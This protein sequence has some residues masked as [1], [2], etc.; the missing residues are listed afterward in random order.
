MRLLIHHHAI[1][2]QDEKGFWFPSFIGAWLNELANKFESIS[3]L[4]QVSLNKNDNLDFF[5]SKDDIRFISFGISGVDKR[6]YRKNRI[7]QISEQERFSF[8]RILIRGITPSQYLVYKAF[9]FIPCTFLMVGSLID[10][11]PRFELNKT[12]VLVYL[13]NHLRIFQLRIMSKKLHVL[14]NSPTIVEEFKN[15]LGVRACF[16]PTNTISKSNFG[17]MFLKTVP[18]NPRLLFVGRVVKDKG[19]QELLES[20]VFLKEKGINCSLSVVGSADKS[21]ANYLNNLVFSLGISDYVFFKGFI[22]FGDELLEEYRKAD[23]Y[24][25]PS[26]HE[27]FPHSIWEASAMCTPIISTKV[28]G[29]PGLVSD[30]EV[31]FIESKSPEAISEAVETIILNSSDSQTRVMAAYQLLH[32]Y[33]LESCVSLLKNALVQVNE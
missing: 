7:K 28:G 26:Y 27:G 18:S 14:A 23:I 1:V 17:P 15:I 30:E 13:L 32:R 25:L 3:Y 22:P 4:G 9:F 16:V 21:F 12:S 8:D 33:T 20:L 24:V 5:I 2:F 11:K 31:Y 6:N 10:N 19:I 29:I